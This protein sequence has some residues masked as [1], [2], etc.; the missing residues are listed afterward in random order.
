[1]DNCVKLPYML[2]LNTIN[3][4]LDKVSNDLY[5]FLLN[6]ETLQVT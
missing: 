5:N 6:E 4:T 1:M 3:S 2:M